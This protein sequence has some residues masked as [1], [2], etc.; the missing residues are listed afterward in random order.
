MNSL[1]SSLQ[2]FWRR[3]SGFD[4]V[5]LVIFALGVVA[6]AGD[7]GGSAFNFLKF[8]AVLCLFYLLFR[9]IGW[10]RSRLLWSLRNR[11]IVAYLF[12]AL[13]PIL[14]IVTLV[15]LAGRILYSQL[16]AYLLY[17]D[18]Q[19]RINSLADMAEHI[20]AAHEPATRGSSEEEFESVLAAQSKAV[21]DRELPGLAITF[22]DDATLLHS[23]ARGGDAF[24]GLVQEEDKLSLVSFRAIRGKHGL[25]VVQLRVEVTPELL[26]AIAPDVG[27]IQLNPM[28]KISAGDKETAIYQSADDRYA[29][30]KPINAKA[31]VLQPQGFWID[32]AVG[33]VSRLNAVYVG[34]SGA[35][36]HDRP[37]L[38]VT[39]ARP[40]RLSARIF[41]SLGEL[42]DSYLLLFI[43]VGVVFLL[44]ELAA[45]I[46][47]IS[48]TRTITTAVADLYHATQ[49]VQSG[50][51]THRV[52]VD[53]RDQLG[54]LG[55]SF[56]LMTGSISGLIEEQKQRQRL[57]NEISIAREVQNQLFPKR[58]PSVPGVEVE[59]ICKA[60]RSVSGDYYDF[61]QLTPTHIAVA[62]ADISGKGISA[63]LLMASLQA[64]LRSQ[65][66]MYGSEHLGTDELV[67][68]L[69]KHLVRNTADDRFAT[70][71]ICVYDSATRTMRYTNAGH[72]P[73]FLLSPSNVVRLDKGGM[74]LGVYEESEYEENSLLVP[75]DA[76]LVGYSD[77]LVEPENVYGEEFGIRR[78]QE[79][80]VR[81]QGS[82]PSS[83]ALSLMTSAEEWAGSAEQADDMTVIVARMK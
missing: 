67:S 26:S 25:R 33:V 53:R 34:R 38:A 82:S 36:E 7:L 58:L 60:A 32:P 35:V 57:E 72:L 39:N 20:A 6:V 15:G 54:V 31:R 9:M 42:R 56:N 29:A 17:E 12:I 65:L 70:F 21:H 61:I 28:R 62:I 51:L 22:S 76:V 66:L 77:G 10:W 78:L 19:A 30:G 55:E 2:S 59:A 11:L 13:V 40:S 41:N 49:Y 63:A 80:A 75:S 23:V 52:R 16:G 46:T 44:I 74:V 4:I 24:A 8:L 73:S 71:F 47:G 5:A 45:L 27:A 83:V 79:A 64:A 3:L 14:L 37:V 50:D 81:V 1:S 69:N 18:I 68:R 48:M 43:V